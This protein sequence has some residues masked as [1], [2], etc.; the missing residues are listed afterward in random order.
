MRGMEWP[1]LEGLPN[2]PSLYAVQMESGVIKVGRA[3]LGRERMKHYVRGFRKRG[4]AHLFRCHVVPVGGT[5]LANERELIHR[6]ARLGSPVRGTYES[7]TG[8]P[9]GM[10]VTLVNQIAPRQHVLNDGQ[11]TV[12]YRIKVAPWTA[13]WPW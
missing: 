10:A 2:R 6:C 8:I 13:R 1:E 4:A 3:M 5:I 7:F 9:W 12:D 11:N